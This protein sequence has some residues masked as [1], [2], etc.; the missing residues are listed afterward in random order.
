MIPQNDVLH[1]AA[2]DQYIVQPNE[3]NLQLFSLELFH[4]CIN[5]LKNHK[6]FD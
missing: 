2:R 6:V 5:F 1:F 3:S 4:C